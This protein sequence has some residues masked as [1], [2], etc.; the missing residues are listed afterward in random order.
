M[1]VYVA[2]QLVYKAST[3]GMVRPVATLL[4]DVTDF[5]TLKAGDILM[6]GA[7]EAAPL[8]RAGQQVAIEIEGLGRLENTVVVEDGPL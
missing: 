8:A 1:L 3:A 4:S 2:G 5:M 7:T 6:L